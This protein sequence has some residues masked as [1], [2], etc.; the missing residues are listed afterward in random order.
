MTERDRMTPSDVN[1]APFPDPQEPKP[2]TAVPAYYF[3]VGAVLVVLFVAAV[4][5]L[6]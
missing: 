1:N 2:K 6:T 3:I 4:L 5:I